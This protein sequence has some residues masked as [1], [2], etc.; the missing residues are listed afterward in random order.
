MDK[1]EDMLR[2]APSAPSHSFRQETEYGPVVNVWGG[3]L[4]QVLCQAF[5][6]EVSTNLEYE[7]P[8]HLEHALWRL[9]FWWGGEGIGIEGMEQYQR[10]VVRLH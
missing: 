6:I 4:V 2:L 7:L 5:N 10:C 8:R 9:F 3:P 1:R